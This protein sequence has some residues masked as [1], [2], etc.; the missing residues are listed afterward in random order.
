[1]SIMINNKILKS[2]KVLLVEDEDNIAQLLK[3][4]LGDNFRSFLIAN[5]GLEGLEVFKKTSPD[6]II[7]DILMPNLSGLEMASKIRAINKHIP[8]IILSAHSEK[9]KLFK[10][11]DI[12][13]TK[14]FTKPYDP[15]EILDY[16]KSLSNMFE[17]KII[18]IEDDF[19]FNKNTFALYKD[20]KFISLSKKEVM[21]LSLLIEAE[22]YLLDYEFT[23][24]N[25]WQESVSDDRLRTFIKRLREKTSKTFVKT[26]NGIGYKLSVN[27][28]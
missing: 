9:D 7:T 11:I 5:D 10:A 26:I 12:G 4:A 1:M 24:K 16:I 15:D 18:K 28:V 13:I 23:K 3:S 2:L 22:D 19:T 25:I 20:K 8:I 17:K 14:Y 21:F 27:N 6:I